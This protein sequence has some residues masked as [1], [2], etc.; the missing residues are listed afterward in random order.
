MLT[1]TTTVTSTTPAS[2]GQ[3]DI[4][5]LIITLLLIV[6]LI[7]REIVVSTRGAREARWSHALDTAVLPLAICFGLIL[8]TTM[9]SVW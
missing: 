1:V 6:L 2:F 9:T 8:V 3:A 7:C 5:S 4:L